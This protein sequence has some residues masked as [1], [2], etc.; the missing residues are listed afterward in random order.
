MHVADISLQFH[1]GSEGEPRTYFSWKAMI[2]PKQYG[3][4][5]ELPGADYPEG[6]DKGQR[7][8]WTL[9]ALEEIDDV[10]RA[11]LAGK[12]IDAQ[13]LPQRAH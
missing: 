2:G 13:S 8:K 3:V 9:I 6:F 12:P 4:V 11:L 10:R 7:Q 1:L 5:H